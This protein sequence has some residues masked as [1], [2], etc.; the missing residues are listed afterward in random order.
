MLCFTWNGEAMIP[1]RPKAAD[2]EYV[3]GQRYWLE[4]AS[5]RS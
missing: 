2:K 4:Q 3:I 5:E 1:M